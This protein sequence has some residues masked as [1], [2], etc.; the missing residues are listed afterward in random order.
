MRNEN[1]DIL[2]MLV[3]LIRVENQDIQEKKLKTLN[4]VLLLYL[5]TIQINQDKLSVVTDRQGGKNN[6]E[7][8]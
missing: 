5:I 2:L 8:Q 7:I 6:L 3:V 1:Q 4:L